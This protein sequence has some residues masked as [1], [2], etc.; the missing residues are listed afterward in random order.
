MPQLTIK[1]KVWAVFTSLIVV[2]L[3]IAA[4]AYVNLTG[5]ADSATNIRTTVLPATQTLGEMTDAFERYRILEAEHILADPKD[6]P[7]IEANMNAQVDKMRGYRNSIEPLLT[8]ADMRAAYAE[9]GEHWNDYLAAGGELT[10]ASLASDDAK[11]GRA[12]RVHG[13]DAFKQVS[14]G[15]TKLENAV[16]A[17]GNDA[18]S[19][20]DSSAISTEI[21]MLGG[22]FFAL[23]ICIG[24]TFLFSA[25]VLQPLLA[26]NNSMERLAQNDLSVSLEGSDRPDEIGS[27]IRAV[28]VFKENMGRADML[29]RRQ[30]EEKI[31]KERRQQAMEAEISSFAGAIAAQ[32]DQLSHSAERMRGASETMT[33]TAIETS[34]Q[35]GYVDQA[36]R[37]AS[38][39]VDRVAVATGELAATDRKSTRL[40]SSHR[41]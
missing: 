6:M 9:F 27:M 36:A 18:A 31:A 13:A 35:A 24:G 30:N 26:V 32:I 3:L 28:M 19:R 21:W 20:S 23:A 41:P 39:N 34:Q 25:S 22:I 15:L 12:Y 7:V 8:N 33:K 38:S 2:L 37:L 17:D 14:V 11:S 1:Q 4:L 10:K 40:N 29:S 16:I 5:L